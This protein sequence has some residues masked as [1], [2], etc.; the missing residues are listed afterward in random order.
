MALNR[1]VDE[2]SLWFG[3][4]SFPVLILVSSLIILAVLLWKSAK[5]ETKPPPMFPLLPPQFKTLSLRQK[6]IMSGPDGLGIQTQRYAGYN[7]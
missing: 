4:F 5:V 1:Q 7:I 3:S 6:G 2:E